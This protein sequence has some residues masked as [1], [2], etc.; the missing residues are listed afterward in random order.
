[1]CHPPK[2]FFCRSAAKHAGPRV[3]PERATEAA[4]AVRSDRTTSRAAAKTSDMFVDS[5]QKRVI[6]SASKAN[7]VGL[8]NVLRRIM[9]KDERLWNVAQRASEY[10]NC[11]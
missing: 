1:M 5:L 8:G 2:P 10:R 3:G 9:M 6:G 11:D 4:E 7:R